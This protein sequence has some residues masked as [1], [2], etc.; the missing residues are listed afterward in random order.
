MS[1]HLPFFLPDFFFLWLKSMSWMHFLHFLQPSGFDAVKRVFSKSP[2]WQIPEQEFFI[3]RLQ[4]AL[5]SPQIA[6]NW[7]FNF[8]WKQNPAGGGHL[9]LIAALQEQP[10]GM[11]TSAPLFLGSRQIPGHLFFFCLFA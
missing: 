11:L 8:L 4:F 10:S 1:F 2:L 3:A 5:P 9:F 7:T 6:S